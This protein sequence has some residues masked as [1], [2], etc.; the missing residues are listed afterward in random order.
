VKKLPLKVK[1]VLDA[2]NFIEAIATN[3]S[4]LCVKSNKHGHGSF[5]GFSSYK[6]KMAKK[7]GKVVSVL[8]LI[9][10]NAIKAYGGVDV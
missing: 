1:D 5:T 8:N 3:S 10:H 9:K 4:I 7:K 2:A 6:I